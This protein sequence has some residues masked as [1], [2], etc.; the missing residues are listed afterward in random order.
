MPR[1]VYS[2]RL[3]PSARRVQP[4]SKTMAPIARTGIMCTQERRQPELGVRMAPGAGISGVPD[5]GL[6]VGHALGH[7]EPMRLCKWSRREEALP[8]S[9]EEPRIGLL[10]ETLAGV[11]VAPRSGH[12]KGGRA[13]GPRARAVSRSPCSTISDP[14]ILG[15]QDPLS[16]LQQQATH[17]SKERPRAR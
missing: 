9:A 7:S 16:S 14:Q 1:G 3:K 10:E 17:A 6:A 8:A 4:A 5:I 13:E 12:T 2:R 11:R 15:R